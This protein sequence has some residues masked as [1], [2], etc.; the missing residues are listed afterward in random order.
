[1]SSRKP[2]STARPQTFWSIE[3]G[4][5]LRHVDRQVVGLGEVD[6]LVAGQ[7]EVADRGDARE[8]GGEGGDADLEP[9][10]VVALAGAAVATTVAPCLRAAATRCLTIIGPGQRRDQRVAVHVERVGLQRGQAVLVGELVAGVDDLG[11]DGAAGQ[12]ALADDLEVLAALA[13][14][15]RARR[16][17]RRRSARRSSR[18]P[19]RCPAHPSRRGRRG[20]S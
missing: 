17:P 5:L 7:R 6:G 1:M 8:V 18:S 9:H 15:D 20:Q 10:L 2:V 3:Y 19:R 12:G 16:S 4:R 11:L 13:D 14:V